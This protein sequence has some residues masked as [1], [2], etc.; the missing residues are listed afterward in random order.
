MTKAVPRY[1]GE[2]IIQEIL[3]PATTWMN[4]EDVMLPEKNQPPKGKYTGFHCARS[5]EK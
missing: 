5:P 4:F 1:D 2:P 3:T